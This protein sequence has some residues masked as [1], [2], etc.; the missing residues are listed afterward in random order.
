MNL[1]FPDRL[2]TAEL[3]ETLTGKRLKIAATR[4][5]PINPSHRDVMFASLYHQDDGQPVA[6]IVVDLPLAVAV[7]GMLAGIPERVIM[8]D[9]RTGTIH[10]ST[11][12]NLHEVMNIAGSLLNSTGAPH[13][14]LAETAK[15]DGELEGD[16]LNLVNTDALRL[17]LRI[18]VPPYPSGRFAVLRSKAVRRS[19]S[20]AR[21]PVVVDQETIF[22]ALR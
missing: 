21:P 12:M 9:I 18:D 17:D 7:S 22:E 6:A 8:E 2:S 13:L 19:A 5:A 20:S 16:L 15:L 4:A 14:R 10:E 3:F 1:P 11:V